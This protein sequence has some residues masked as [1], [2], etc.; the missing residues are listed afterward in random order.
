MDDL[1]TAAR[2]G[3]LRD[4]P[5]MGQRSEEKILANLEALKQH[6]D[7]RFPLGDAWPLAQQILTELETLPGVTQTAI[8]GSLRRMCETI[9]DID[10][11]V[12]ASAEFAPAIMDHFVNLPLVESISGHGPTKSR[13]TLLNGIG[14]DLRVLPAENWGTLL[15]YFT[16]SKAHNVKLREQGAPTR[17]QS[18]TNTI[19]RVMT[20]AIRFCAPR[21]KRSTR[22]WI[23]PTL[24]RP[25]AKIG[26][27]S[28]R[29]NKD[30]CPT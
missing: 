25:C 5:G 14:V 13:V 20:A 8:G 2:A 24:R 3:K 22:R 11:L 17:S 9:G 1:E 26:A 16:G 18:P 23:C 28:R 30:V 19:S 15:S 4:L 27:K 6:G 12:C 10:L 21:K 7:D 29:P